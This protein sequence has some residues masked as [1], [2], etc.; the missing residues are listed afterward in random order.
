MPACLSLCIGVTTQQNPLTSPYQS[1][2]MCFAQTQHHSCRQ[3]IERHKSTE[4][5]GRA[6]TRDNT[7]QL[8]RRDVVVGTNGQPQGPHP[9]VHILPCPYYTRHWRADSPYSRGER[10]EDVVGGPL[11][12]PVRCLYSS[13]YLDV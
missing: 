1:T 12:S 7:F 9:H 8:K 11:W 6:T 5:T 4:D 3:S 10:G 2:Q 13:P